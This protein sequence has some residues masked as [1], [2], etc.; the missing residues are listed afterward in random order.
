MAYRHKSYA[1]KLFIRINRA[2]LCRQEP[3][4]H[5]EDSSRD[6]LIFRGS[7]A[8]KEFLSVTGPNTCMLM[9]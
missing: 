3:C 1:D 8:D 5:S 4:P 9:D 6:E 7:Y 2:I